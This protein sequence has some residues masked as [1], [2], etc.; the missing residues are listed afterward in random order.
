MQCSKMCRT[1]SITSSA[2]ASSVGGTSTPSALAVLRLMTN[3][4]LVG[5]CTGRSEGAAPFSILSTYWAARRCR[6]RWGRRRS[7]LGAVVIYN[8]AKIIARDGGHLGAIEHRA[9]GSL[10]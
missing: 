6:G 10:G 7:S 5:S 8:F 2:R 9:L 1:Y 4:N 3:S